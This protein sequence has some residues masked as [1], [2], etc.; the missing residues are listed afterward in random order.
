M[1]NQF[2]VGRVPNEPFMAR[3]EIPPRAVSIPWDA[4]APGISAPTVPQPWAFHTWIKLL[5]CFGNAFV[6]PFDAVFKCPLCPK[7]NTMLSALER[8]KALRLRDSPGFGRPRLI[9][10]LAHGVLVQL[11]ANHCNSMCPE[12]TED[13]SKIRISF[14]ALCNSCHWLLKTQASSWHLR[15][16]C[17]PGWELESFAGSWSS[18]GL[19]LC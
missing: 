13:I 9:P 16:M 10:C 18:E 5:L 2:K 1:R 12:G 15:L 11:W 17:V 19:L 7:T 8:K 4:W 3:E 6:S 14:G